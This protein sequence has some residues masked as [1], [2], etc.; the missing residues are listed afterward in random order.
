VIFGYSFD[1]E[2]IAKD[3]NS[4]GMGLQI[5]FR[6]IVFFYFLMVA[7]R[8][9]ILTKFISIAMS[10]TIM[11]CTFDSPV[12]STSP[13]YCYSLVFVLLLMLI[14]YFNGYKHAHSLVIVT[15]IKLLENLCWFYMFMIWYLDDIT[16][17]KIVSW[18]KKELKISKIF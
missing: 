11:I 18:K 3:Y 4:L 12:L 1:H 10:M 13:L 14:E 16:K 8:S 15:Q 5:F 6:Q 9:V 17:Y 2:Q 7:T